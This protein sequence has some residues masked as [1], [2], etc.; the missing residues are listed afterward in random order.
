MNIWIG[1]IL[2]MVGGNPTVAN[3]V[4]ESK[5]ACEK[6]VAA[7]KAAVEARNMPEFTFVFGTCI[8]PK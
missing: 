3:E 5:A 7:A 4:F 6:E 1:I 8:E 2:L